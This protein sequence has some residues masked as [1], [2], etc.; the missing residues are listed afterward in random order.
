MKYIKYIGSAI[1]MWIVTLWTVY[2]LSNNLLPEKPDSII[3]NPNVIINEID[4]AEYEKTLSSL[5]AIDDKIDYIL[6]FWKKGDDFMVYNTIQQQWKLWSTKDENNSILWSFLWK[7][8]YPFLID[9]RKS[10][11]VLTTKA[12]VNEKMDI[13]I[14]INGESKWPVIKWKDLSEKWDNRYVFS[15]TNI[16]APKMPD[17]IINLQNFIDK[18]GQT[19]LWF[20]IGEPYNTAT[21]ISIVYLK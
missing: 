12:P 3:D 19:Q 5:E 1:Y 6:N 9:K 13:L 18:K 8:S 21:E 11:I 16:P 4:R 2:F 20:A 14:A 10:F 15:T 7:Y 17:W